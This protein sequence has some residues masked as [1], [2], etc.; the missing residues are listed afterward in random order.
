MI[1]QNDSDCI[2]KPACNLGYVKRMDGV[3]VTYT[4]GNERLCKPK[5][6]KYDSF[7]NVRN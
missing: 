7:K 3:F 6:C 5:K 4:V 1:F 2:H